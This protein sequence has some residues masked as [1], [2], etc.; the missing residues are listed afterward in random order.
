MIKERGL[1]EL[2]KEKRI[3]ALK[4]LYK[5]NY[6]MI[7]SIAYKYTNNKEDAEEILQETFVRAFKSIE[8]FTSENESSLKKWILKICTNISIDYLRK[9]KLKRIF[10]I[11]EVKIRENHETPSVNFEKKEIKDKMDYAISFLSPKQ[12]IAFNLKYMEGFSL[13]EISVIMGCSEN[14]VKK[15]LQRGTE[16]I[17]KYLKKEKLL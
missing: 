10:G 15:H 5:E 1:I 11:S 14:T 17:K 2:L 8:K 4:I 12:R 13:R 3:E 9:R 7:F 6:K 16:K